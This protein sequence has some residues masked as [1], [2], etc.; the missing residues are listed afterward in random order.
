MKKKEILQYVLLNK[1]TGDLYVGTKIWARFEPILD[2]QYS[3]ILMGLD[4]HDG[5]II[6]HP[7]FEAPIFMNRHCEQFLEVLGEL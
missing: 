7:I 3:V 5:W 6:E 2:G 4:D 1:N